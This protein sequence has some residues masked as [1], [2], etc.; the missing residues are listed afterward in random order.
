[1]QKLFLISLLF[2][3]LISCKTEQIQ[4]DLIIHVDLTIGT[5]ATGNTFP[6][7]SMPFGGVQLSPDTY[8]EG[9]CSGYHYTDNTIL[10]FSHTHLSGTGV[11]DY[12]D[13]LFM[14]TVGDIQIMPGTEEDPDSG[15][16]SRF[17]HNKENASPGYYSVM[18]DDYGVEVELTATSRVGFHKYTFPTA[19]DSHILIDLEHDITAGEDPKEDCYIKVISDTE[20]E[21]LRHSRGWASD[22]YVYFV[23]QFSEPFTEALTYLDNELQSGA[24]EVTG[25]EV[26]AVLNYKTEANK[27]I[28]VKVGISAVSAEGARMN[29]EAELAD[30]DFDGVVKS[31]K[32][33]WNKELQKMKV[34]GGS[35][36]QKTKFYTALYHA[37]LT[38]NLYQDVDGKYRGLDH[39]VHEGEGFDYYSVFSLWDTYRALHP[40]INLISPERNVDFVKTMVKQYE[41]TGLLPVWELSGCENNCMIGYHSVPVIVD[42]YLKGHTD[43][44][45][46]KAFEAMLASGAQNSE[47]I[48]PY[49]EYEFIPRDKSSNS[50]S[51][52]LEYAYDDW[53]IAQFAKAIGKTEVY[54]QYIKRAQFY[55]NM[56]DSSTGLMRPRYDDGTWV[57]P[58]D[59]LKITML[60]GGDFTEA[61][62]WQYSFYV[63]HD[64]T[65]HI[66]LMGGDEQYIAKLDTFFTL[67]S[68]DEN[69]PSDFVG[70]F[71]QYAHGNEPS[72]HM[73]YLYNYAGA[74][75]KGQ[76]LIR[77]TMSELYTTSPDGLC[78]NDDCG[79]LSAWYLFSAM[80]F[81]PV[82]P[83]QDMY[84]IG[85]P[86]FDEVSI[87][88][89]NGKTF[90]VNSTNAS[91]ENM[92]IQ[93]AQL[94]G[95]DYPYSYITH[96]DILK[97]GEITFAMGSTP[98]KEWGAKKE[99][100]PYSIDIEAGNQ[101]KSLGTEKIFNPFVAPKQKL[102]Y[103]NLAIELGCISEDVEIYYT[104]DG[105]EPDKSKTKYSKAINLTE[106]TIVKAKAFKQGF[107]P[108]GIAS[109]EFIKANVKYDGQFPSVEYIAPASGKDC[110]GDETDGKFADRYSGGG[111]TALIDGKLGSFFY[112]DGF[113]QGFSGKDMEVIVDLGKPTDTKRISAGFLQSIGVWI[114]HPVKV[115]F[116]LSEDGKQF[117]S[118]GHIDVDIRKDNCI[119]GVK[120][121]SKETGGK[122]VRYI[123]VKAQNLGFCP[124]WHHGAGGKAWI[125][126]DEIIVE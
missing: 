72:H 63:P 25:K 102:F 45:V 28:M 20:I 113:W 116:F 120:Y 101:L 58:F 76:E 84:A 64:V 13:V 93:S 3:G 55:K 123:K 98:N 8:N 68:D 21:G 44:D 92:F 52:V 106:S 17:N 41:H 124:E 18:L 15:Y 12:G 115:E 14:P 122:K 42:T 30:W 29:L 26:K 37:L 23:A 88:L 47:G 89:P 91:K 71:G 105:T 74:A 69:A 50:V 126:A 103:D 49:R 79:Q 62:A 95:E 87:D 16:R 10:G 5:D 53:C 22:Q 82:C 27:P 110:A 114:F 7:P 94:N 31:T 67:E 96:T 118:I 56:Y 57:D 4:E 121:F 100:R 117:E 112:N 6:G 54:E 70:L 77:K 97:G 125:F 61:N 40:L 35:E 34:K 90:T 2:I 119:D 60:D 65:T 111:N 38:P 32:N 104:L 24:D 36:D 66:E 19:E 81:Y 46:D 33:A 75:W 1:M 11:A 109:H 78:G 85:S 43:F 86:I 107:E 59:P 39:E 108:S 80:G 83:G 9:C 48:Q 51:K 73:P 99:H